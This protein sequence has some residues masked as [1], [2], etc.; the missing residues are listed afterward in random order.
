MQCF[1]LSPKY[2]QGHG[3][4]APSRINFAGYFIECVALD[5]T[6][7]PSSRGW[8]NTSSTALGNST[9]SSKNRTPRCARVISPG[10]G[11][12]PPPIIPFADAVWWTALNGRFDISGSSWDN[13][14]QILYILVSSR[15]SGNVKGGKIEGKHFAIRVFPEPGDPTISILCPPAAAISRAFF[16][17]C[18]PLTSLKSYGY[19]ISDCAVKYF[20]IS[21]FR[22]VILVSIK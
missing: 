19:S 18:C 13:N 14:P 6:I 22:G 21:I 20:C 2:P 16:A 3:F 4:I 9:I 8:R 15:A 1:S 7:S 11:L 12:L 17:F 5:I 10:F